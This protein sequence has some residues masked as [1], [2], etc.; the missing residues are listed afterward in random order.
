MKKG[1]KNLN[2]LWDRKVLIERFEVWDTA[3]DKEATRKQMG[4]PQNL[5]FS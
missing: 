4:D 5:Q 2:F 1:N 3:V